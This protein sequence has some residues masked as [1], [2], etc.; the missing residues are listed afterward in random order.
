[1]EPDEIKF[2]HN[3]LGESG[4]YVQCTKYTSP[5][6]AYDAQ[7]ISA[8]YTHPCFWPGDD[9]PPY[10]PNPEERK[11]VRSIPYREMVQAYLKYHGEIPGDWEEAF[12]V[13]PTSIFAWAMTH[14]ESWAALLKPREKLLFACSSTWL[15]NNLIG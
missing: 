7:R 13:F 6:F 9:L 2:S 4:K 1:M 5:L 12:R 11:F 10:R 8:R 3:S 15:K 14:H